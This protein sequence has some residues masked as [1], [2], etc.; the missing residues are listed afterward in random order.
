MNQI[1]ALVD[2]CWE[3][4]QMHWHWLHAHPELSGE[5]KESAAYIAAELTRMGLE[6]KENVG[7]YGVVALIEGTKPGKCIG[8]RADFDALPIQE[9]TGLPFASKNPGV[10]H[11]CGHDAHTAMLLGAA[12]VLLHMRD[13]FSGSVKLIFQPSEEMSNISGARAM[14]ADGVLENPKVDAV[15]GQHV[16][17]FDPTGDIGTRPG[18]MTAAS[19]KFII[20][21]QGK[22]CHASE[23]DKGVDAVLVGA[24]VITSLQS[25][26]SR[27]VS[28][29]ESS[30]LTIG[31]VTAGTRHNVVAETCTMEGTCRNL[32]PEIRDAVAERMEKI[33]KGVAEGM[34]AGYSFSYIR[35]YSPV[36]NDPELCESVIRVASQMLGKEHVH[37]NEHAE[38]GGEDFSFYTE[39]VPGLYYHL[40]CG[41]LGAPR[42]SVHN[43]HFVPD[44]EALKIG[45]RLLAASA[46]TY[47]CSGENANL[48]KTSIFADAD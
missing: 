16:S 23:P 46:L 19:D 20:T 22:G 3:A 31:K 8:L 34:G 27:T 26:I 28:P 13:Q 29:F 45:T 36:I 44:E 37:I 10:M 47:L 17:P 6:P 18:P 4:V 2:S 33:V 43:S 48:T 42:W 38:M 40:G 39:K 12:Y 11:A 41:K 15:I 25:I 1:D 9:C 14:I 35:G 7:G 5:E 30:V 32:K 24:Q 21:I